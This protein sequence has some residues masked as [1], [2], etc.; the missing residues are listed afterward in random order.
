[1]NYIDIDLKIEID[2]IEFRSDWSVLPPLQDSIPSLLNQHK[3][4]LPIN[5]RLSYWINKK[6]V[7]PF[8]EVQIS[9]L[10][11]TTD[12]KEICKLFEEILNLSQSVLSIGI[13]YFTSDNDS[14]FYKTHFTAS[15]SKYQGKI[16]LGN[17]INSQMGQAYESFIDT[18]IEKIQ[19]NL[20]SLGVN[21]TNIN[22]GAILISRI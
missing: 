7:A 14:S 6:G 22:P 12:L 8:L 11:M 20:D 19:S 10:P 18:Q 2:L 16:P 1:M 5:D 13:T 17:L 3:H 4:F 15:Y 9:N 21:V